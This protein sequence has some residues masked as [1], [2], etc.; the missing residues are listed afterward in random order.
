MKL[1]E[2]RFPALTDLECDRIGA[3]LAAS[4]SA[5]G[6]SRFRSFFVKSF[7]DTR[8]SSRPISVSRVGPVMADSLKASFAIRLCDCSRLAWVRSSLTCRF[9]CVELDGLMRVCLA[10]DDPPLGFGQIACELKDASHLLTETD[11]YD[12]V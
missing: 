4:F 12:F 11:L 5:A 9:A 2:Y 1:L 7:G 8:P 10:S 6:E 3:E